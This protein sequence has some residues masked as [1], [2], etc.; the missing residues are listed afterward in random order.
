MKKTIQYII[1]PYVRN[2]P[3]GYRGLLILDNC[4]AH[5]NKEI[6]D[7][8]QK[9]NVDVL[10]LPPNSTHILQPLDISVFK[11]VKS[12]FREIWEDYAY[13]DD[14]PEVQKI[15]NN[16]L[17]KLIARTFQHVSEVVIKNGFSIYKGNE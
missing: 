9:L 8:L 10:P 6:I 13:R 2:I 5:L 11:S 12:I 7:I 1:R 4:R 3:E 16:L 15:S 14:D 17:L